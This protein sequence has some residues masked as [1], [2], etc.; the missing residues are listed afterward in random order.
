MNPKRNPNPGRATGPGKAEIAE[1]RVS[2]GCHC[3]SGSGPG[4]QHP[5]SMAPN[6]FVARQGLFSEAGVW[7]LAGAQA[8]FQCHGLQANVRRQGLR[9]RCT[10]FTTPA[11]ATGWLSCC[12]P[13]PALWRVPQHMPRKTLNVTAQHAQYLRD[14]QK[15]PGTRNFRRDGLARRSL[16]WSV[17]IARRKSA[18]ICCCASRT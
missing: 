2:N 16:R 6:S 15:L 9:P 5:Q 11:S 8:A 3:G 1:V 12:W 13:T 18:L 7:C 14:W 17:T 10:V 4:S